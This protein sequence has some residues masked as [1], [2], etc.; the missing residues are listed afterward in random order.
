MLFRFSPF[1]NGFDADD[2]QNQSTF[3]SFSQTS[4]L[5]GSSDTVWK[6]YWNW[7]VNEMTN[8]QRGNTGTEVGLSMVPIHVKKHYQKIHAIVCGFLIQKTEKN[9]KAIILKTI[10]RVGG[11]GLMRSLSDLSKINL[12][13]SLFFAFV[14]FFGSSKESNQR[15]T[16]KSSARDGF[17]HA[18]ADFSPFILHDLFGWNR[19]ARHH[20]P[21][22]SATISVSHARK[23]APENI[24][25][26][27][28]GFSF[29][30]YILDWLFTLFCSR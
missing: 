16:P 14:T 11:S 29:N 27:L 19:N 17:P 7:A 26:L 21:P 5:S 23:F 12:R 1:D 15:K 18:A 30:P 4:E 9:E 25:G 3:F 20:F 22:A 6:E 8:W 10:M 24:G 28:H 13:K 2:R